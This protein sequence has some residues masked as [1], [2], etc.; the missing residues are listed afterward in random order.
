[1]SGTH[2]TAEGGSMKL[3]HGKDGGHSSIATL[4]LLTGDELNDPSNE[5]GWGN[6]D[7]FEDWG[8]LEDSKFMIDECRSV[9]YLKQ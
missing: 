3:G 4:D 5:D 8:S 1:M 9:S 6:D 7:D 2:S